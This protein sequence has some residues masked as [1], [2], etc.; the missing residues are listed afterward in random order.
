[1]SDASGPIRLKLK[2]VPGASRTEIAGWLGHKLKVRVSAAPEKGK[3]NSAVIAIIAQTLGISL[4]SVRIVAGQTSAQ[5]TIEIS[6]VTTAQLQQQ[7][8]CGDT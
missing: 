5:K 8:G 1:M 4:G 2:V 6:G 3:A 7:L